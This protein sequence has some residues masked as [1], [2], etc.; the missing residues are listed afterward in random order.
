MAITPGV[1]LT[2]NLESILGGTE[3]GGF[4]RIT[5]CG[6]GPVLPA[7]PNVGMLADAGIPMYVGP[8]VGS[9]PIAQTLWG[10]DV[11]NPS[12]TF[13]EIALLDQDKDVIQAGIYQLNNDAGTVDLST[14]T[15]YLGP[16]GF[17]LGSLKYMPCT[18]AVPG[19]TYLAAGSVIAVSYNG[20]FLVKNPATGTLGY[21]LAGDEKTITLNFA[22]QTGDRIDALCVL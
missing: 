5:L 10:N 3:K 6:F 7:V 4:L 14:L 1:N 2:A 8:Q 17:S 11:I 18:G 20:I 19:T 13:Y 16:Y 9:T 22:T 12:G 15:Q 21:T